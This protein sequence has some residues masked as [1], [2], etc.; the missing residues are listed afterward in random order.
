MITK[1]ENANIELTNIGPIKHLSIPCPEGGGLVVLKGRNDLGKSE[2]LSAI[3]AAISG[4]NGIEVRRG[5]VSGQMSAFGVNVKIGKR[6]TR[7]GEAVVESLEGRFSI[8]DLIEPKLKDPVAADA[9][10]I[11]TLIQV[12]GKEASPDLFYP[13]FGGREAF[14]EVVS[15]AATEADDLVVMAE[16]IKRDIESAARKLEANAQREEGHAQGVS[17]AIVDV[18]LSG[19]DDANT[20]QSAMEAAIRHESA[21]KAKAEAALRATRQARFAR[22]NLDTANES[23]NGPSPD[24]AKENEANAK[25]RADEL[26]SEVAKIE[27]VLTAKKNEWSVARNEYAHAI[28]V[29]KNAEAHEETIRKWKEQIEASIP[30]APSQESLEAASQAVADAREAVGRGAVIARAKKA[31]GEAESHLAKATEHRQ[32]AMKLR[33]AA[34]GTDD[35]LSSL[36]AKAGTPLRVEAGRLMV[37]TEQGPKTYA[38]LSHGTRSR[39]AAKIAIDAVGEGGVICLKQEFYEGLAPHRKKELAEELRGKGVLVLTAQATDDAE[40]VAE[41]AQ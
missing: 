6:I 20:L 36:V 35:I 28:T 19:E 40:I 29:R 7:S 18:D 11:K 38:E 8:E 4:R 32:K 41:I 2:T 10:R 14:E 16:R 17:G 9:K 23:Y 25:Q 27:A 34:K 22:D 21:L 13:L 3:D 24:A 30:A 1:T 5:C 12:T 39:I 26:Q 31:K 33:D 37:D 15:P